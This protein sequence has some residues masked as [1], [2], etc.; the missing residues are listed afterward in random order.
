MTS[1]NNIY[2]LAIILT[3]YPYFHTLTNCIRLI[4]VVKEFVVEQKVC[5]VEIG[6]STSVLRNMSRPNHASRSVTDEHLDRQTAEKRFICVS[7][8]K[9]KMIVIC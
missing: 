9:T 4:P 6:P 2:P 1:S 7:L 3:F 8:G 5:F